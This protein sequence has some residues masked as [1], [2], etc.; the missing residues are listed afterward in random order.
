MQIGLFH[1]TCTRICFFWPL[2]AEHIHEASILAMATEEIYFQQQG[3]NLLPKQN[4]PFIP[5]L[6]ENGTFVSE[7]DEKAGIFHDYFTFQ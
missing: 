1:V 3:N 4:I 5:P 7:S 6:W 2:L